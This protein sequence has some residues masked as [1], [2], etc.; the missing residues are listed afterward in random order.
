MSEKK[1]KFE[2]YKHCVEANQIENKPTSKNYYQKKTHPNWPQIID[3][4]CRMLIIRG[5]GSGKTN[6]YNLIKTK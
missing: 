4:S 2:N 5:S 3:H 6:I 1:H